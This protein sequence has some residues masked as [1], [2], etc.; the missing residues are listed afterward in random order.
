MVWLPLV[1][2]LACKRQMPLLSARTVPSTVATPE[3]VSVTVTLAPAWAK[4]DSMGL[5][6]RLLARVPVWYTKKLSK[7]PLNKVVSAAKEMALPL[8]VKLPL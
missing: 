4:P 5:A 1:M 7:V 6:A 2:L 8:A 3:T